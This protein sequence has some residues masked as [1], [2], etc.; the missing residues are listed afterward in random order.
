MKASAEREASPA[1][2]VPVVLNAG[3]GPHWDENNSSSLAQQP[4]FSASRPREST[5]DTSHG[6]GKA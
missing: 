4:H 2:Q 5:T 3:S 1:P 6:V